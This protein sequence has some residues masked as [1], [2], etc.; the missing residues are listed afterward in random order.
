MSKMDKHFS[1]PS[2]YGY[3]LA[4]GCFRLVKG[5]VDIFL[6]FPSE[7]GG[8]SVSLCFWD[9]LREVVLSLLA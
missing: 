6:R 3:R 9:S 4:I 2:L 7:F 1:L 5:V 8:H